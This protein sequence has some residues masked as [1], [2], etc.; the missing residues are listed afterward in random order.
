MRRVYYLMIIMLLAT[1][2][3]SQA[4]DNEAPVLA[5]G[6]RDLAFIAGD[7]RGE[8]FGGLADETWMAPRE[9][10]MVGSFRLLWPDSGRRLYEL[11][12]I[13]D[14]PEGDVRLHFRHFDRGME[15]W[16]AEIAAPLSFVLVE[17]GARRAV[18]EASD[19]AQEPAR[20]VFEGDAAGNALTVRVESLDAEGGVRDS[21]E[22][23]YTR[24]AGER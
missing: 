20:F 14:T 7:W 1:P 13:E 8:L 4:G 18:F 12:I 3:T 19:P 11:L 23:H 2:A 10:T 24:R 15:L 6:V 9:G 22:A 16:E 21:F 5:P 17:V